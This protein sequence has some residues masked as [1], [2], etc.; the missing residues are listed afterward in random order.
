MNLSIVALA[1]LFSTTSAFA[2]VQTSFGNTAL[3]GIA[4]DEIREARSSY[5]QHGTGIIGSFERMPPGAIGNKDVVLGEDVRHARTTYATHGTG[6]VGSDARVPFVP[7]SSTG[8][9]G[10]S[11][12]APAPVASSAVQVAAALG[13]GAPGKKSYAPGSWKK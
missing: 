3:Y 4:G 10:H 9:G 7:N 6:E 12:A 5:A 2:P 13:A 8:A 11:P 1:A